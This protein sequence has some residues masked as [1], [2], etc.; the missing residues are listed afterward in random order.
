[1]PRRYFRL[2][3]EV[4]DTP[5]KCEDGRYSTPGVPMITSIKRLG[6]FGR[7]AHILFGKPKKP[8]AGCDRYRD[9]VI[10]IPGYVDAKE[11]IDSH[12]GETIIC[13]SKRRESCRDDESVVL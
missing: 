7:L 12:D 1:M 6:L 8:D 9:V 5:E 2:I 4:D 11:L 13:K 10:E 3:V